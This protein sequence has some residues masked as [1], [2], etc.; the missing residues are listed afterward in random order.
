[1]A[2][3]KLG[4]RASEISKNIWL[5]GLGAYG[6][7]FDEASEKYSKASKDVPKL[8]QELV[9]KGAKLEEMAIGQVVDPIEKTTAS[10][11]SRIEKMRASLGF[12]SAQKD[13]DIARLE[14]KLDQ[15]VAAVDALSKEVKKA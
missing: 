9:V 10:I 15:V 1:M 8:F 2:K 12:G 3:D 5:A 14:A 4:N 7:A 6:K 11:E 13:D